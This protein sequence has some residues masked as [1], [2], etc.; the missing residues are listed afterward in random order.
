MPVLG[1]KIRLTAS[2]E[3]K[4]RALANASSRPLGNYVAWLLTRPR[5][6]SVSLPERKGGLRTVSICIPASAAAARQIRSAAKADMRSLSGYVEV[7]VR[8][9]VAVR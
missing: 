4:L 6:K 8:E 1:V 5:A 3:R 7:R 9:H 2:E